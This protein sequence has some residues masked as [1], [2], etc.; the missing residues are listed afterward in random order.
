MRQFLLGC[1]LLVFTACGDSAAP[2]IDIKNAYIVAP[3]GGRDTTLAGLDI[4]AI[5]QDLT[6]IGA[7]SPAAERIEFHTTVQTAQGRM[8]MSAL[9]EITVTAGT[10][11]KLGQGQTHLMIFGFD[12]A[13]TVGDSVDIVLH[14][15]RG[16]S[17]KKSISVTARVTEIGEIT[18]HG[19]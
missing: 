18:A 5:G 2:G 15:T 13:L 11:V 7:S 17:D 9:E 6:L 4:T 14:F 10:P 12:D 3:I 16:E 1:L 19:S 8:R